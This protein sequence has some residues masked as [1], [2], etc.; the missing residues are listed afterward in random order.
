MSRATCFLPMRRPWFA[1]LAVNVRRAVDPVGFLV[2]CSDVVANPLGYPNEFASLEAFAP[3][4]H[5]EI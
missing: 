1:Q 2:G 5:V 3:A 4:F